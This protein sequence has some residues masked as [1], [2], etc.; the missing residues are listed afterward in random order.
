M[1]DTL[2]IA[3]A[4]LNFLVGDVWGNTKKIIDSAI[5]AR[6][7]LHADLVIFS[8]LSV[9]GYP[10]EDLL[11]RPTILQLVD[12][13][14]EEITSKVNGIYII[15]GAPTKEEDKLFNSAL[16]IFNS[17]VLAT[18]HKHKLPNYEV[19]DEKRYFQ[20]GN[21]ACVVEINKVKV[22]ITICEDIW[23]PEPSLKSAKAGAELIV[24]INASP[25]HIDKTSTKSLRSAGGCC[26]R[27]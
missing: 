18:Y 12:L 23:F 3:L 11:F 13:A 10:L 5:H 8:E 6:D 4:Q 9:T 25:Y 7:V 26:C 19:F 1:K 16:L 24:N 20:N 2:K 15:V 21:K 17:K 27:R 22:G 14:I